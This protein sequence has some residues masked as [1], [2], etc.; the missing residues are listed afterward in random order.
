M[1][2][3]TGLRPT[4]SPS[5]RRW[6]PTSRTAFFGVLLVVLVGYTEMAFELE[7]TS[8]GG[9]VGPGFF[10][11]IIGILGSV[12]C[13]GALLDSLRPGREG[14][15]ESPEDEVGEGDLG[16]HPAPLLLVVVAGGLLGA[17]FVALGAIIAG[18]LFMF[19]M[20]AFLNPGRWGT[21]AVLS[22]AIPLGL[23][24]LFQTAL[25]AGLPE[26]LLPRF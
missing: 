26:G 24:L 23:Y 7:W 11:R 13:L 14:D 1:S 2:N 5:A 18:T 15:E 16:R 22:V 10:P 8:A 9:R 17:T 21:N 12:M 25:N 4:T 3:Q 6:Q 19:G 20:L